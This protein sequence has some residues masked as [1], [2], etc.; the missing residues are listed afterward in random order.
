MKVAEI[1]AKAEAILAAHV[2][3][4]ALV[5]ALALE[6][7]FPA[8]NEAAAKIDLVKGTDL[9]T[10]AILFALTTAEQAVEKALV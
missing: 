1:K 6:L 10:K 3:E 7:V 9:E 2:D 4:K 5:K 8:L